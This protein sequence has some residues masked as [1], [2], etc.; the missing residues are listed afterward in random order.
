MTVLS[1][2]SCGRWTS[3]PR[4]TWSGPRHHDRRRGTLWRRW[5][6]ATAQRQEYNGDGVMA[7]SALQSFEDP[8]FGH[9][10]PPLG[11][12]GGDIWLAAEVSR[13]DGVAYGF[14]RGVNSGRVIAGEL[15]PAAEICRDRRYRVRPADAPAAKPRRVLVSEAT[16]RLVEHVVQLAQPELVACTGGVRR[17]GARASRC[18]TADAQPGA[19][20]SEPGRPAARPGGSTRR[21]RARLRSARRV[22]NVVGPLASARPGWRGRPA[23]SPVAGER[24]T[25]DS[26][27]RTPMACSVPCCHEAVVSSQRRRRS[28]QS[29]ARAAVREQSPHADQQDLLPSTTCWASPTRMRRCPRWTRR[30]RRR[31]TELVNSRALACA[32][33]ALFII[34]D[35][36]WIDTVSESYSLTSW[37]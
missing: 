26:A 19:A 29:T 12:P 3:R 31:L 18:G 10:L 23:P 14:G 22:V 13:R 28:R 35:A 7:I 4:W 27:S 20:R 36:H 30:C 11:D 16:A 5:R 34:E 21:W 24:P 25:G 15:G 32:E 37:R 1:P 6:S 8:L 17:P 2:T 33:P 9:A